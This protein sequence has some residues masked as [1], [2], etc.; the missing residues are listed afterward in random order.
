MIPKQSF[1]KVAINLTIILA[2][3]LW[4]CAP[5]LLVEYKNH[6]RKNSLSWII[7]LFVWIIFYFPYLR[8]V[9]QKEHFNRCCAYIL[10]KYIVCD[11]KDD[12]FLVKLGHFDMMF[13]NYPIKEWN[14]SSKLFLML[15]KIVILEKI[16]TRLRKV[17]WAL[18]EHLNSP[19]YDFA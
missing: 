11:A 13:P 16:T 19:C 7:L 2:L 3:K 18:C 15:L 5:T 14:I 6:E 4:W 10:M 8:R 9:V 1:I 12:W 17:G